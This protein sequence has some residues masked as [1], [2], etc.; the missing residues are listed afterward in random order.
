MTAQQNYAVHKLETLVILEALLKWED[1][2]MEY[3]IHIITDHKALE[4]FKTQGELNKV[5]D[6]LS[7]YF[8][9]DTID[10][11]HN[12][13]NYLQA[14]KWIDPEG[15]DLPLHKFHKIMEKKVEIQAMQ[16]RELCCS[17]RLKE[18]LEL[19]D[20]EAQQMVESTKTPNKGIESSSHNDDPLLAQVLEKR[21]E[22][23]TT[24]D[25]PAIAQVLE[26]GTKSPMN[27]EHGEAQMHAHILQGYKK[28]Q[29]YVEILDKLTEHF[30]FTIE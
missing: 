9:S 24:N 4:F 11:V 8:E 12:V 1:K 29:M 20:L 10:D 30:R 13:Y 16:A 2:L 6:C 22:S 21:T 14:D 18:Q 28:D 19:H 5:A 27:R 23:S 7:R 3:K 25:D 26:M 15:E 17:K